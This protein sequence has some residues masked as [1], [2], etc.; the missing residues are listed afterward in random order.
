MAAIDCNIGSILE[1]IEEKEKEALKSVQIE[2]ELVDLDLG[3]CLMVDNNPLDSNE[4]RS[5]KEDY[6]LNLAKTNGQFL[7]N[8][9]ADLETETVEGYTCVKL[10][11]GKTPI[12]RAL[13]IPKPKPPTK[14]ETYAK[15]KGIQH[16]KREKLVWDDVAKQWKPRYGYNRINST[17]DQWVV[18]VPQNKDEN[19]DMFEEIQ[20]A[21]REKVAKNE[22]QR[23]RNIAR[24]NKIKGSSLTPVLPKDGKEKETRDEVMN[25]AAVARVS[26]ASLGKFDRKLPNGLDKIE[27]KLSSKAAKASG[28]K[29]K[30]ES[31]FDNIDKEKK[32]Y[33]DILNKI[34]KGD[35]IDGNKA[36]SII[37]QKKINA[38]VKSDNEKTKG[39][40]R[41]SKKGKKAGK[42]VSFHNR[43]QQKKKQM[44]S[45]GGFKGKSKGGP[46]KGK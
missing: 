1:Q 19:T 31:N 29:R 4:L 17:K 8:N 14:W 46:R 26:T 6:L 40:D 12:P 39:K 2:K 20:E 7:M 28:K 18:E 11:A 27:A 25:A 36:L 38:A 15:E 33:S 21:K 24:A 41:K 13:P 43:S 22:F 16:K 10:P 30:F 37:T 3:L 45:K 9:L 35:K 34:D 23:L 44:G 5:K 32:R 42:R